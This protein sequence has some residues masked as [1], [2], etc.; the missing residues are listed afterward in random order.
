M[1]SSKN[2]HLRVGSILSVTI[3][4]TNLRESYSSMENLD[5]ER[6]NSRCDPIIC[7][8]SKMDLKYASNKQ[9]L[10]EL[11]DIEFYFLHR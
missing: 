1:S 10:I 4:L 2:C 9:H 5:E 6:V 11:M 8:T 7:P 3:L